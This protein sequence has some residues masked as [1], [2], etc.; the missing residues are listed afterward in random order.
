[1]FEFLL[2]L[3]LIRFIRAKNAGRRESI[4]QT[5]AKHRLGPERIRSP[6]EERL[7]SRPVPRFAMNDRCD[8]PFAG[9]RVAGQKIG[10][11]QGHISEDGIGN[12]LKELPVQGVLV[13]LPEQ[14]PDPGRTAGIDAQRYRVRPTQLGP[15][16]RAA[17]RETE[18]AHVVVFA[19]CPAGDI[20]N[21][22][23]VAEQRLHKVQPV[24]GHEPPVDGLDIA[25][26]VIIR[27]PLREILTAP[28]A[29]KPG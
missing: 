23:V 10:V 20:G 11:E 21:A 9:F 15:T 2:P 25:I 16:D 17:V 1:M 14:L 5:H 6:K 24:V 13:V 29:L 26:G 3:F 4:A 8:R 18:P 7:E 27:A 22:L 19:C 12:A 28:D